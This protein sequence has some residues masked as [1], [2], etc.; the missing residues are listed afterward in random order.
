MGINYKRLKWIRMAQKSFKVSAP[1]SLMLMGEHAILEKKQA[2]VAA[3]QDRLTVK[4]SFQEAPK[5]LIKSEALGELCQDI[6]DIHLQPP[7]EY[8]LS[9]ILSF[10][11]YI[12][13]GLIIEID[14]EFFSSARLWIL[15]S[16]NRRQRR[17]H[18]QFIVFKTLF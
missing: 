5:I 16:G 11:S 12:R 18:S 1:G 8:V 9:A 13:K 14:S 6:T 4:V 10:K 17:R 7:F 3:I 15:F 2:L